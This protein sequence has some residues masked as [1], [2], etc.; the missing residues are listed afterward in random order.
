[1]LIL[2]LLSFA[3][4]ATLGFAAHRASLCTVRAV[5]EVLERRPPRILASFGKAVLWAAAI[6]LPIRWLWPELGST[7]QS[8]EL[9]L[10]TLM[11]GLAFGIGAALNGACTFSTLSHIAEGRVAYL[12]TLLGFGI[13][14][15][16]VNAAAQPPT[17]SPRSIPAPNALGIGLVAALSLAALW[18]AMRLWR[19]RPRE[20]PWLTAERYRVSTAAL[21]LGV[22]GAML[23]TMQGSW[24]YTS[25]LRRLIGVHQVTSTQIALAAALLV[26][27]LLSAW[28]RGSISLRSGSPVEWLRTG[29]G[30]FGM[31]T[32][33]AL[34]PGG[35]A[36]LLL[37][38][39]PSLSRHALPAYLGILIGAA[40]GLIAL[41]M[42]RKSKT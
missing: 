16:L 36:V 11:G 40:L 32:G 6:S 39:I 1:M 34:I 5:E 25:T 37:Y 35:N 22:G 38:G 18:E 13:A 29:M 9:Q 4:A 15:A 12:G 2:T 21:I 10:A 42:F 27:M 19:S 28:E 8:Y 24:S 23:L 3:I 20:G 30:G 26:G 7:Q 31:G 17:G 41:G 14:T 33:A